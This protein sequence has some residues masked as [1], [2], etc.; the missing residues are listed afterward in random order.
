MS[1]TFA[2]RTMVRTLWKSAIS[3]VWIVQRRS[4]NFRRSSSSYGNMGTTAASNYSS[5]GDSGSTS[6]G[7]TSN[8]SYANNDSTSD[9]V[10][11]ISG[12]FYADTVD[13]RLNGPMPLD[14]RRNYGSLN[15]AE[16]NF[17]NGW[18]MSYFPYLVFSST[19]STV[20]PT[21]ITAAE[22]DGS[23]IVYRKQTSG[24]LWIPTPDDNPSLGNVFQGVPGGLGNIYNN[25][26]V[27]SGTDTFI[28][29]GADGSARTFKVRSFDQDGSGLTRKRPYLQTW[30]DNRG[31]SY[32]FTFGTDP[33]ATDYGQVNRIQSSNGNYAGFNYDTYGHIIEAYSGDGRRLYYNYDSYGDLIQ[34]TLPDAS[35]V[36]YDYQHLPLVGSGL[37][38]NYYSDMTLTTKVFTRTDASINFDW[39]TGSPDSSVPADKFSARWTGVVVP[40]YSDAYT[41]YTKSDDGVRLWVNGKLIVDSWV[42]QGS[43]EH[44]GTITLT[45]GQK[46]DIQVAYYENGGGASVSL[47]WSSAHQSKQIVP[48]SQLFP[49]SNPSSVYSSHLL[50]QETKPG[51]RVL[52]NDYDSAGRVTSQY[53]TVGSDLTSVLSG[54][55]TYVTGTNSDKTLSGTTTFVDARGY[56]TTYIYASSQLTQVT[57]PSGTV[58]QQWY[59]ADDG[60][61]GYRRSLKSRTD[62]RGLVTNYLYDSKGNPTQVGVTGA[63]QGDPSIGS[64]T[65]TTRSSFN[66]RNLIVGGTDPIGNVTNYTYGDSAHPYQATAVEKRASGGTVSTNTFQYEDVAAGSVAS[67]GL[68]KQMTIA[69]GADQAVTVL[70]NNAN[71]FITS[72]T[73]YSNTDDPNSVTAYRYNLRGEMLSETDSAGRSTVYSYDGRGNRTG[74]M[75]YDAS[76]SLAAFQF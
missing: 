63:L 65:A 49:S 61:G 5:Y 2:A 23:V 37:T 55:F 14:I 25:Q 54:S 48:T 43:V 12:E 72:K 35:K 7:A 56:S 42:D 19:D 31:N 76:G 8:G 64:T 32:T 27:L 24:T 50:T 16:N 40:L 22:M 67:Y 47:S 20:S 21:L 46:Y 68:L 3:S 57:D 17:G 33:K 39:G 18:R 60:S 69:S 1:T 73:C 9:P 45:A 74:I 30:R 26:I 41:F 36:Q 70:S 11:V 62:K 52:K 15:K 44:S 10:N 29:N 28:L 71:G 66:S 58:Y 13:L 38:G 6:T 51:G 75:K 59:S 53:S 4:R 34:V